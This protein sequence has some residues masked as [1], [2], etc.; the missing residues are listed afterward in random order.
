MTSSR[1]GRRP[2]A[3]GSVPP[4]G[5]GSARRGRPPYRGTDRSLARAGSRGSGGNGLSPV[6]GWSLAFVFVAIVIVVAAVVVS[7]SKGSVGALVSPGVITPPTVAS[8]GRTL[9]KSDAPVT[10][11]LYGDFRCSACHTVTA[12]G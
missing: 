7:Q 8:A 4:T 5:R 2:A 1:S 9:G 6:A 11:D 3:G 12:G 10:I